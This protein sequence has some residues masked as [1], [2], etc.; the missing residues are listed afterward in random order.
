VKLKF[1]LRS[2]GD[3]DTD[4]AATVDG[5]T[6]VGQLSSFLTR[7]DPAR[8]ASADLLDEDL[9]LSLVDEGYRAVDPRATISDSGLRSGVH[10]AITRR[11]DAYADR[12]QPVAT[13]VVRSGPDAGREYPL[14]AGTAYLGRGRGAE[15]QVSDASVSRRHAKLLVTDTLEV[16]DL[17]SSNGVL[18]A[19]DHVDRAVL[20]QGDVF[21]VGDTELEVR[22]LG[23]ASGVV[24]AG[25]GQIDFSRS[26]RIAPVYEGRKIGLPELPE[27]KKP[28]RMPLITAMVPALMGVLLF[29]ITGSKLALIFIFMSPLMVMGSTWESRRNARKDFEEAMEDFREDLGFIVEDVKAELAV[30]QRVRRGEQPSTAE[31][32]HA[33]EARTPVLWTR[34]VGDPG[35]L[36]LRLGTGT[37]PSRNVLEMPALG[38]TKAEAWLELSRQMEGLGV[39]HDVPVVAVPRQHGAIGVA[40]P[41]GEALPVARSLLLQV[42]AL[43]SPAEVVVAAFASQGSARDWDWLKWVPHTASPHSPLAARHTA[44]TGPACAALLNELEDLPDPDDDGGLGHPHVVVLVENDAPCDRARL[45]QLAEHGWRRGVVVLWLAPSTDLLPAPCRTYVRLE[46]GAEAAAGYVHVAREVTPVTVEVVDAGAAVLAARQLSPVVDSGAPVDDDSDLPRAVSLLAL[47]GTELALSENAVIERWSENRS[48]LTGPFAPVVPVRK[49]GSLR[50]V[51]G[52]SAT[53]T[54][55][56]DLRAD[57]PHALVGG[58]TG[59]GKSEL[60]Q[61]WI[62]GMASAHSPQ[63]VTFLLV[64]YK[65]GSAF[66]DCVQLPHT[67]GLVTDLSPHLVRRALESLSAELRYREHLLAQ[68]KAKDLVELERRGEVEAPPS[69]VIVV[70]EFAALVQE[71][72]DFV[73]G[74][75]NVAQRGRSLG[76]HLILA[77]QRPAGVIKDNLRANTNL[78]MALRMADENDS[79]DVL[80]STV[81]AFFDPALPGRAVSKS[82][83]GRLTPFQ[84]GYAGGWTSDT[85]P[86]PEMAVETLGFGSGTRWELPVSEG[87]EDHEKADLGPTDIQRLVE[88]IGLASSAARIPLPRKP[89]LPELE[90]VYDLAEL[91]TARRDDELVLGVADVP[92]DQTQPT[93]SFLPDKEGNLAVYGSSGSGK[94]VLLRTLAIAAGFTVRGGPCHVYGLDFGNRGLA[95]LEPLP[96][97]GS[98]VDGG[99]HERLVRLMTML[100]ETIDE[101]AV[102]YSR[103]NAA[104]ITDYRR[105]SGEDTEPRIMVLI[106]GFTAFRQ[107][108]ETSGAK[109]RYLDMMQS[110]MADGRPVGVHFIL[111][112]DARNGL[113]GQFASAI[114]RRI[115][116]RMASEE[117]YSFLGVPSDVLDLGSP[118]GR[119]LLGD[120][121]LQCAVLGGSSDVTLQARAVAGFAEAVRRSGQAHAPGIGN[122]AESVALTELPSEVDGRPVLG[123]GSTALAPFGFEP[124]GSFAL[125]GPSGS[126]RTTALA[127]MAMALH[128]WN[129]RACLYLF[130]PR[131]SSGLRK[132]PVWAEQAVGADACAELAMRLSTALQG[133]SP[134]AP[135]AVFIERADDLAGGSADGALTA[136]A[137]ACIDAEQFV[138]AEGETAWFGSNF[139]MPGLLKTSRSGLA[140]QP[141]GIESQT[142][143]KNSFPAFN[144]AEM[145]VGRGFLVQRGNTELVQVGSV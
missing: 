120:R 103:A 71:V 134:A 7:A 117:D 78:R 11:S 122:L 86:P 24:S 98:V 33:V 43:H 6:T 16:Q 44:S 36:E 15:V 54:F 90:T 137:K 105:L 125:T 138:V 142:I 109:L 126:G 94:S 128:R 70:D 39:V 139:G 28:S 114:Q 37:A 60:L 57:G 135:I 123:L 48:I 27:R 81:A 1:T 12:G 52:Q 127:A 4:L 49:P 124:R 55:S 118:P 88:R 10:V 96:H 40:G 19:G 107:A 104:T 63:R 58:T 97:V 129:A 82:G 136:L 130:T 38:R 91:T 64:D 145:P 74:V 108:Y 115:V 101:R 59:A 35:F 113:P 121:E 140:L 95:M 56:V 18:I 29:V 72:P 45:V 17:G 53:G 110:L 84:T 144:R 30:E 141:E 14:A 133:D 73:D 46:A 9:T 76:L 102:R 61:A 75:V 26:P 87:A 83:P 31:C 34:R 51:V 65:G 119:A 5:T 85:P 116:L 2:S 41:R 92:E 67:V 111:S 8:G 93:V 77:T 47:T 22:T 32:L 89:W 112:I 69:L 131:R 106:D 132:L 62:L 80:G 3:V 42:V 99:D 66:R 23:A 21:V 143:F 25:H 79:D 68:Y 20:K 100:R 50:A 13:L